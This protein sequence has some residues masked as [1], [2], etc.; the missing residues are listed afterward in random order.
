MSIFV[1]FVGIFMLSFTALGV[2]NASGYTWGG[3]LT[4]VGAVVFVLLFG[5]IL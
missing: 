4:A 5:H 1:L 3:I 2:Y